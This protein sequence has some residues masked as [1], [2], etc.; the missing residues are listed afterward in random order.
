MLINNLQDIQPLISFII[1]T[2]NRAQF[3]ERSIL[4][5]LQQSYQNIEVLVIDDGSNDHTDNIVKSLMIKDPRVKYIQ[6]ENRGVSAARNK[7]LA[8]A[9]GV[10]VVF[11]D[12]DDE[13]LPNVFPEVINPIKLNGLKVCVSLYEGQ[14]VK[15]NLK[16]RS[17]K[18]VCI[19]YMLAGGHFVL[20]SILLK[21]DYLYQN[22][23][24]FDNDLFIGEDKLFVFKVLMFTTDILFIKQETSKINHDSL[25]S[26]RSNYDSLNQ[27]INQVRSRFYMFKLFLSELR[28]DY[29]LR[30][31]KQ[32]FFALKMALYIV[33][34]NMH[35]Q[36]F[37]KMKL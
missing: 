14:T 21:K 19:N 10:Y 34:Y 31:Y 20:M 2:Y 17:S 24:K 36:R 35:L 4:S 37:I 16:K 8:H 1:P 9:N 12:S 6:Q 11:L 13:L 26:I 3:I 30:F 23:I 18:Q 28:F 29:I 7:G 33:L 5:T 32:W 27:K 22:N 25:N 15:V